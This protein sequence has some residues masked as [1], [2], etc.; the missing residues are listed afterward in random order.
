M[1]FWG[2]G[3]LLVYVSHRSS[4]LATILPVTVVEASQVAQ[5]PREGKRFITL[6]FL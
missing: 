3:V 6:H 2:R 4:V 1:L 5:Y